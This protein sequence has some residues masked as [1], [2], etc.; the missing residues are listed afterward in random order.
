MTKCPELITGEYYEKYMNNVTKTLKLYL[1]Y[2]PAE[3][4]A[5]AVDGRD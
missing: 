5:A 4:K 1:L 3:S 2:H